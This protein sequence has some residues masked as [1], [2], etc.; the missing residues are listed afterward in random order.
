MRLQLQSPVRGWRAVCV[1]LALAAWGGGCVAEDAEQATADAGGS[2]GEAGSATS[3]GSGSGTGGCGVGY[4]SEAAQ[5][6]IGAACGEWWAAGRPSELLD[7]TYAGCAAALLGGCA[8]FGS[9]AACG[10]SVTGSGAA[11]EGCMIEFGCAWVEAVEVNAAAASCEAG[12]VGGRCVPVV[13]PGP[14]APLGDGCNAPPPPPGGT[15]TAQ[16]FT[17]TAGDVPSV[18]R[19]NVADGAAGAEAPVHGVVGYSGC[20]SVGEPPVPPNPG[21]ECAWQALCAP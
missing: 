11:P 16:L 6:A 8:E 2:D 7:S 20:F 15:T 18:V 4:P 19:V 17:R 14:G 5:A 9:A 12:D 1:L 13:Q 10:P 21:C 3:D